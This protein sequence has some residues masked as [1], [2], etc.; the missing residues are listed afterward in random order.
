MTMQFNHDMPI[1]HCSNNQQ[2][3]DLIDLVTLTVN[4]LA[5]KKQP[6]QLDVTPKRIV[7]DAADD[8]I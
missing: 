8:E 6:N 3:V 5:P 7:E 4:E 1:A 2:A